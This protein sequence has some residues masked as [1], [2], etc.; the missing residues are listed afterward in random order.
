MD[1]H[2]GVGEMIIFHILITRYCKMH[3]EHSF[4]VE[5]NEYEILQIKKQ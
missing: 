3:L 4:V 5:C 1:Y 2:R